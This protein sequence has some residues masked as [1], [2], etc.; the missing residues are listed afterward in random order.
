MSKSKKTNNKKNIDYENFIKEKGSYIQSIIRKTISSIKEQ[1]KNDL[2]SNNDTSLSINVLSDLYE[3]TNKINQKI[4]NK[5]YSKDFQDVFDEF[6]VIIDKLAVIICGFGT[7]KM[8]DLLFITFGTEF[9]NITFDNPLF[10][11]KYDLIKECIQPIGYKIIHWKKDETYTNKLDTICNN[12]I[13]EETI[14]YENENTLECFH[15]QDCNS[16]Y[17]KINGVRV[18]FQN[19]KTKKNTY[20]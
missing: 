11:S 18:I 3:K 14:E 10:Q 20:C 6:Q 15:I 7:E 5:N 4:N 13:T 19:E 12:K 9:K 2:F 16:F 1:L 17:Q 8:D